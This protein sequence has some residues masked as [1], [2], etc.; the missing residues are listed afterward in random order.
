MEDEQGPRKHAQHG[1]TQGVIPGQ[2][3]AQAIGQR[4]HPLAHRHLRQLVIA[5]GRLCWLSSYQTGAHPRYGNGQPVPAPQ[6]TKWPD[7]HI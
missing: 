5:R 2:A 4:E 7:T 1:A 3:V 6:V